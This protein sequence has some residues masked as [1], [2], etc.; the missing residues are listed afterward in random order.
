MASSNG[1]REASEGHNSF[2]ENILNQEDVMDDQ[3]GEE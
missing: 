2:I 3:T 1:Q